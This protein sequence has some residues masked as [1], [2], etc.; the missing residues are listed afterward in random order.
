MVHPPESPKPETH[1]NNPDIIE[2]GKNSDTYKIIVDLKA[3]WERAL[4]QDEKDRIAALGIKVREL[5]RAGTPCMYGQEKVTTMLQANAEK[6]QQKFN[7]IIEVHMWSS[8]LSGDPVTSAYSWFVS[9]TCTE[10]N[11]KLNP[12]WQVPYDAFDG[13]DTNLENWKNWT[14]WIYFEGEL[15]SADKIGNINL[16]YVGT[17][18]GFYGVAIKNPYTMD[19]DDGPSVLFGIELAEKIY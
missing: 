12:D 17:K 19:K 4:S 9:M 18:M 13:V 3:R 10:W 15:R 14:P 7:E 16:G 11:Y 5:A 1:N 6:G 8:G 2:F